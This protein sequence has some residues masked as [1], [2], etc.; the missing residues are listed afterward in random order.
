MKTVTTIAFA[1]LLAAAGPAFAATATTNAVPTQNQ[2]EK[3]SPEA[4]NLRQQ[5]QND[6]AKAGFTDIKIMPESFL[7]RAKDSHGN[8]V[9]MVINPDSF[10]EVTTMTPKNNASASNNPASGANSS[11]AP[12]KQ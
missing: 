8:P 6:L 4:A 9:M 2:A 5:M 7:V 11:Q 3:T 10:T 12:A 1:L